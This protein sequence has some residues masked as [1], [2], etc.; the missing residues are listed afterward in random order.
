MTYSL[1]ISPCPNDTFIFSGLAPKRSTQNFDYD[2][3]YHDIEELNILALSQEPGIIKVSAALYPDLEAHYRLLDAGAAFGHGVGP[4]LVR[5]S[6]QSTEIQRVA[7]PGKHTTAHF[8]FRYAYP[9]FEGEVLEYRFDQIMPRVASGELDAGVIIHESRFEYQN[10]GLQ[11][12]VDLGEVWEEDTGL[13]IPL[14]IILAH[15]DIP[16]EAVAKIEKDI[17]TSLSAAWDLY[18][19]LDPIVL[20]HA[21]EMNERTVLQHIE[22]YVNEYSMGLDAKARKALYEMQRILRAQN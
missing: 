21:Q 19:S 15:R 10:H 16:E 18:P 12:V 17:R 9:E 20:D 13:P 2:F 7:I 1:Y 3:Y 4:L 6:D 5:P 14:G 22:L 11:Q 8:L